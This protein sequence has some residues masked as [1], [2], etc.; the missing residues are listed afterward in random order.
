MSGIGSYLG[1]KNIKM[2]GVEPKGAE[3]MKMSFKF[4]RVIGMGNVDNFV[5][6]ASWSC[7][8]FNF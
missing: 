1:D 6:G 5:D 7:R 3:S 8:G 2:Y 4:D